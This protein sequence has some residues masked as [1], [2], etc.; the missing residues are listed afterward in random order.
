MTPDKPQKPTPPPADH[1]MM[2]AMFLTLGQAFSLCRLVFPDKA[3]EWL[4]DTHDK[5][6]KS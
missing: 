6:L 5:M 1:A 4:K 2:R 3:K